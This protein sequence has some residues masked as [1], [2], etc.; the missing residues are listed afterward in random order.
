MEQEMSSGLAINAP[1]SYVGTLADIPDYSNG[2][3][4]GNF[5]KKVRVSVAEFSFLHVVPLKKVGV[6]VRK[7]L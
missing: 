2:R 6:C 5:H 4:S 7:R 1:A 3:C